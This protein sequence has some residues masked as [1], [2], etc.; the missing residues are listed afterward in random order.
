MYSPTRFPFPPPSPPLPS[1]SSQC[2]SPEHLSHASSL[3]WRSVSP[4]VNIYVSMLFSCLLLQSLKVCSVYLCLFFCFAYRVIV[5]IFLPSF[6]NIFYFCMA[7]VF[8]SFIVPIF[9]WNVP[10]VSLIFLLLLLLSHSVISDSVWPHKMQPTRLPHPLDSPG[11]NTGVG[12]HFLL[13][14]WKWTV[15]LK[16]LSHVWLSATRWTAAYQALP[17]MGFS[18]QEYW[19]GLPLPSP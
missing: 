6:F 12:C 8:L 2:T 11:T 16:S 1:G 5:A 18:R 9:A 14:W 10:L 19:I 4:F 13:Q 7:I 17:S 3:G 15:K